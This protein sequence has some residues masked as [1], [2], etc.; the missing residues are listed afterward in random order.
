MEDRVR[1]YSS[2]LRKLAA[3]FEKSRDQWKA[4]AMHL[5]HEL[6][7]AKNQVRAVEKSREQWRQKAEQADAKARAAQ[8]KPEAL[9]DNPK[10]RLINSSP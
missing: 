10:K 9:R 4:K 6:K 7:L 5:R 8:T 1:R 2:P 3:F